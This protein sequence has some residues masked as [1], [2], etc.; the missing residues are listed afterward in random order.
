MKLDAYDVRLL[1][2]LQ[3]AGRSTAAELAQTV[4]LSPSQ[5]QRRMKRLEEAGVIR[6]YVALLDT[7]RL[8]LEVSAIVSVSLAAQSPAQ[9]EAFHAVVRERPEI[10][11][12]Y[13]VSGEADYVLKV[14]APD[15]KGFSEFL[16]THLLA[17]PAVAG[18]RSNILLDSL[19]ATT[20]VP[21]S[22]GRRDE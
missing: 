15:L 8:G 7:E 5:C 1:E 10:L 22:A 21:V 4:R 6:G 14:V 12:C 16:L 9:A 17:L 11:E 20:R 18:V 2:T 3:R 13:M 19:K